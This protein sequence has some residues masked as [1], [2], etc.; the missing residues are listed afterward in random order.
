LDTERKGGRGDQNPGSHPAE[1][2]AIDHDINCDDENYD[3]EL[4]WPTYFLKTKSISRTAGTSLPYARS[5][6]PREKETL[7]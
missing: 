7:T 1:K 2:D 5:Y 4:R 3:D 6:T